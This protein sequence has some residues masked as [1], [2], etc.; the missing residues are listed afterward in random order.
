[1]KVTLGRWIVSDAVL[2][3]LFRVGCSITTSRSGTMA[4]PY[5]SLLKPTQASES[6]TKDNQGSR[7]ILLLPAVG[8]YRMECS[9]QG[10]QYARPNKF[11]ASPPAFG[12][13]LL[14][15]RARHHRRCHRRSR[16]TAPARWQ[17]RVR[18][19]AGD[20]AFAFAPSI[21]P[22]EPALMRT[23]VLHFYE[24]TFVCCGCFSAVNPGA[25]IRRS[26]PGRRSPLGRFWRPGCRRR[27]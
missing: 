13:A 23:S 24:S 11:P 15:R 3:G 27:H 6:P 7:S 17:H 9:H 5:S 12:A 21:D 4:H 22:N 2:T 10:Q 26:C 16:P 1:M 19:V 18:H 20:V 14:L 8:T 25:S